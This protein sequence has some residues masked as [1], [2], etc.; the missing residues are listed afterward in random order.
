MIKER[1]LELLVLI[2]FYDQCKE[3]DDI[4]I[5]KFNNKEYDLAKMDKRLDTLIEEFLE[6]YVIDS[7][8]KS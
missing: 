4:L 2:N 6:P 7:N 1:M 8:E 3:D 5:G